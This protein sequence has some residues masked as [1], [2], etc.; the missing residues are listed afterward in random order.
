[1]IKKYPLNIYRGGALFVAIDETE[2][3]I[4]TF[5]DG[6]EGHP[7]EPFPEHAL[8]YATAVAD[9]HHVGALVRFRNGDSYDP[10]AIAHE[11]FHA[12]MIFCNY[13]ELSFTTNEHE[14]IA[15]LLEWCVQQTAKACLEF[16][17]VL[18]ESKEHEL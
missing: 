6:N 16:E 17:K 18:E 11:C 14:H 13:F 15:Y 4:S 1:M 2:E 5:L 9:N 12:V 8:G 7:I 10:D 3:S